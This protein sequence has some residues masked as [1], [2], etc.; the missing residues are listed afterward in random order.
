[1][2]RRTSK[3]NRKRRKRSGKTP[4]WDVLRAVLRTTAEEG[5]TADNW[6]E[7]VRAAF[8]KP[9]ALS[10][11]MARYVAGH[12]EKLGS[13][14]AAL[15][16]C[17]HEHEEKKRVA[18]Y[19]ALAAY[20]PCAYLEG[21]M[22]DL[23][24]QEWGQIHRGRRHYLKAVALAPTL[25]SIHYQLGLIYH[26]LGVFDRSV[27]EFKLAMTF[28]GEDQREA[29]ARACFNVA[30]YLINHRRDIAGGERMIREAL[31]LMPD[32]PE[33]QATLRML[34]ETLRGRPRW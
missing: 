17:F 20:P 2:A 26:C 29:A 10:E 4:P 9:R 5:V 8:I 14:W 7:K 33:A 18:L 27:E 34:E 16:L 32:Y 15:L 25:A 28:A 22:G 11:Y 13:A 12:A 3:Q 1:M 31:E 6:Q 24:F 21:A 30:A 19:E 23:Y